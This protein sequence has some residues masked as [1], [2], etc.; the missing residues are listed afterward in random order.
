MTDGWP[1]YDG[2]NASRD[3]FMTQ[4]V[5]A[6]QDESAGCGR[7]CSVAPA[8]ADDDGERNCIL[9]H[10]SSCS[11]SHH[12]TICRR[13]CSPCLETNS[14]CLAGDVDWSRR[15]DQRA[16]YD[17]ARTHARTD[18]HARGTIRLPG[19]QPTHARSMRQQMARHVAISARTI[20]RGLFHHTTKTP[21][22]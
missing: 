19:T 2:I 22:A 16:D 9:S 10:T 8:L 1:A 20:L 14:S 5:V 3:G 12:N 21:S 6:H 15:S 11:Q 7:S 18:A 17:Q 4:R 13:H